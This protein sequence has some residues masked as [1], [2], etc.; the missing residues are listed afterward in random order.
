MSDRTTPILLALRTKVTAAGYTIGG[1]T[2][3]VL[4]RKGAVRRQTLDPR[5]MITICKSRTAEGTTRRR[6][7]LW[8]TA[9]VFDVIVNAPYS[10]AEHDDNVAEYTAIRDGLVD[11]L[12]KPP[13]PGA[14][15]VFDM[16]AAP[17]DW[18]QPFGEQTDYD[19][20]AVTVTATVAHA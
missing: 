2:L 13:L 16:D 3:P 17:A 8:Q 18:L 9:Y 20:F 19:W 12:K 10:G 14:P 11:L 6:V 7:G 15:D 4:L 5:E 1:V